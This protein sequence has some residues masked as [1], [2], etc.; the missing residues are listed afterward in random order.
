MQYCG[1]ASGTY[2]LIE[3]KAPEGYSMISSTVHLGS[4]QGGMDLKHAEKFELGVPGTTLPDGTPALRAM[5]VSMTESGQYQENG[6]NTLFFMHKDATTGE[7]M[8]EMQF[9]ASGSTDI[10]GDVI[11]TPVQAWATTHYTAP[12]GKKIYAADASSDEQAAWLKMFTAAA[13]SEQFEDY[14]YNGKAV[15]SLDAADMQA[16]AYQT[17]DIDGTTNLQFD[18]ANDYDSETDKDNVKTFDAGWE[19]VKTTADG[20]TPL[21]GAG[22]DLAVQ[23]DDG[24]KQDALLNNLYT[25]DH[26]TFDD[27]NRVVEDHLDGQLVIQPNESAQKLFSAL[28]AKTTTAS[29]RTLN[30]I[31]DARA[32]SA[33]QASIINNKIDTAMTDG[34]KMQG[35]VT[36]TPVSGVYNALK[37]A[38][39]TDAAV[40]QYT[41]STVVDDASFSAWLN[42]NMQI[43]GRSSQLTDT[44]PYQT[45]WYSAAIDVAGFDLV[46]VAHNNPKNKGGLTGH[47]ITYDNFAAADTPATETTGISGGVAS[48][49]DK[50]IQVTGQ[51]PDTWTGQGE[52]GDPNKDD[53]IDPDNDDQQGVDRGEDFKWQIQSDLPDDGTTFTTYAGATYGVLELVEP[54][55]YVVNPSLKTVTL[56][57]ADA[58][59]STDTNPN[60]DTDSDA[61]DGKVYYTG[62]EYEFGNFTVNGTTAAAISDAVKGLSQGSDDATTFIGKIEAAIKTA[63][64]TG[65]VLSDYLVAIQMTGSNGTT[66]FND[67]EPVPMVLNL[68]MQQAAAANDDDGWFGQTDKL[69]LYAKNYTKKGDLTVEKLD[70]KTGVGVEGAWIGLFTDK[71]ATAEQD[72]VD[73]YNAGKEATDPAL[74]LS[75][76]YAQEKTT[77]TGVAE[78]D[79]LHNGQW[80]V[81][82]TSSPDYVEAGS[83]KFNTN[84]AEGLTIGTTQYSWD[85]LL[86][87]DKVSTDS[88]KVNQDNRGKDTV[89]EYTI[90]LDLPDGVTEEAFRTAWGDGTTTSADKFFTTAKGWSKAANATD[91]YTFTAYR[92]DLG[93]KV[94]TG[95]EPAKITTD[96]TTSDN[97]NAGK[98]KICYMAKWKNALLISTIVAPIAFGASPLGDA[99]AQAR[100]GSKNVDP[101]TAVN[102]HKMLK[103]TDGTDAQDI[104]PKTNPLKKSTI[105]EFV[106][107]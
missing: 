105:S 13:K 44:L 98:P 43:S 77:A 93:N 97:P 25:A 31:L 96:G 76:Y 84:K 71:L 51:D 50:S 99:L 91:K 57:A 102:V 83:E 10:M 18:V 41:D 9:N 29:E 36:M 100:P 72:Y 45:N 92:M 61:S 62:G 101:Y 74:Q 56:S 22:F 6:Q 49:V 20:E 104:Y 34:T 52:E 48:K 53:V 27:Q 69:N 88:S 103:T 5:L 64:P 1:L 79:G 2:A 37:T 47:G 26:Y 89:S 107:K 94:I 11:W 82:E 3:V 21:A 106:Q 73:D 60:A 58:V 39:G 80:V 32:N 70:S 68:P 81:F 65:A 42:K 19:I 46:N 54:A 15:G 35:G 8:A 75:D 7:P 16:A 85:D 95:Y 4:A 55:N 30:V 87:S 59:K 67:L 40:Q 38:L 63:L 24:D 17:G 23:I 12:S 28:A 90:T 86:S 78:F 66:K 33:A 14:T